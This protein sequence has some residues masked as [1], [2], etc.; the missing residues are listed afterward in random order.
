MTCHLSICFGERL[1]ARKKR[2]L[3]AHHFPFCRCCDV[4]GDI[5]FCGHQ[6]D[7]GRGS[8]KASRCLRRNAFT[9]RLRDEAPKWT[10]AL[11]AGQGWMHNT[12]AAKR[13][14]VDDLVSKQRA[15]Y[16]AEPWALLYTLKSPLKC[17]GDV[18][19]RQELMQVIRCSLPATRPRP[20]APANLVDHP[21]PFPRE[22]GSVSFHFFAVLLFFCFTFSSSD[23]RWICWMCCH[24]TTSHWQCRLCDV[25]SSAVHDAELLH[26]YVLLLLYFV[27]RRSG[28]YCRLLPTKPAALLRCL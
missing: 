25:P 8:W 27:H 7:D 1:W 15:L 6:V 9:L 23:V 13:S 16:I 17:P 20:P 28:I 11:P 26:T 3:P 10:Y 21:Q 5:F 19:A 12:V 24:L 18:L 2:P 14:L 4:L 22:A